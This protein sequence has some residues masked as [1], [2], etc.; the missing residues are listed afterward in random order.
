MQKKKRLTKR[1]LAGNGRRSREAPVSFH[2]SVG[3]PSYKE[4]ACKLKLKN[5]KEA[6]KLCTQ[7]HY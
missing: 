3:W 1:L 7:L 6:E 2:P 4:A 5:Y